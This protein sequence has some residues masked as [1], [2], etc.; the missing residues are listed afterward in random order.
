M[1]V[2]PWNGN[3]YWIGFGQGDRIGRLLDCISAIQ[4]EVS[5]FVVKSPEVKNQE[6]VCFA[7]ADALVLASSNQEIAI[8][9]KEL[10]RAKTDLLKLKAR[11]VK[12]KTKERQEEVDALR[13]S[14]SKI[15]KK[16]HTISCEFISAWDLITIPRFGLQQ[17][18]KRGGGSELGKKQ[19][20]IL[21][22]L[23]HCKCLDR[24]R[25][26]CV[27]HG[28]ELVEVSES[29][30]T[31]NCSH[32][33]SKN[34]PGTNRFYHCRF[35]KRKMTRDGNAALNIFKM[36]LAVVI[37]RLKYNS[38]FLDHDFDPGPEPEP[39]SD[40]EYDSEADASDAEDEGGD[41]RKRKK[42]KKRK[43]EDD[44]DKEGEKD[45]KWEWGVD[46]GDHT[47]VRG[48]FFSI[49]FSI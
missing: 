49:F 21:T 14:I 22:Q 34:S 6:A 48:P 8:A 45:R 30:T 13:L 3:E 18:I 10:V 41:G 11:L 1:C 26:T 44:V 36:A 33:N 37:M 15:Q 32:C 25:T 39:E 31:I 35:C 47:G 7:R 5:K 42:R 40:L 16:L 29:T 23:A 20:A 4:S 9:S 12:A 27:K 46:E 38:P 19:K 24:L 17:I 2:C 28:C 43:K